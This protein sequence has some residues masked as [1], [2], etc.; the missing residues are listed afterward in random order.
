MLLRTE[1]KLKASQPKGRR[2]NEDNAFNASSRECHY[3]GKKGHM[4]KLWR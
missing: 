4:L 3:C 2:E 1:E